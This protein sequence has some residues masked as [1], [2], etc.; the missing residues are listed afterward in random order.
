MLL[1]QDTPGAGNVKR[2]FA[3]NYL[4]DAPQAE[5]QAAG[6]SAGLSAEPQAA[7]VSAGLSAEPQAAG[8]SAGLSAEPQPVP[9]AEEAP[10]LSFQL[11]KFESAIFYYLL[12]CFFEKFSSLQ[13]LF[14]RLL[15]YLEVRT[16]LLGG[17]FFVS[18]A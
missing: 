4:S 17:Y 6:V 15:C 18:F 7:G 10:V 11:D 12:F 8:V 1:E 13:F 14:Y 2:L 9:Q 16:F 3:W 5:P